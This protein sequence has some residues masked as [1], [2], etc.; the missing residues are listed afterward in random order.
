MTNCIAVAL[1]VPSQR[2]GPDGKRHFRG[3]E[4]QA[5][6]ALNHFSVIQETAIVCKEKVT[7]NAGKD[8]DNLSA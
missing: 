1:R 3:E 2:S 6:A 5:A 4:K 8:R 7:G